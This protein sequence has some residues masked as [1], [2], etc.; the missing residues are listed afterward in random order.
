MNKYLFEYRYSD[1]E[2]T[3]TGHEVIQDFNLQDAIKEFER[4]NI[5]RYSDYEVFEIGKKL[6]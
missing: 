5:N 3:L 6:N 4:M 1:G 2:W